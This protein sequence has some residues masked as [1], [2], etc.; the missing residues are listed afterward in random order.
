MKLQQR[1]AA[2]VAQG[3]RRTSEWREGWPVLL[4]GSLAFGMS[5][6]LFVMTAGLFIVPMQE[7]FGWSRTSLSIGPLIV[8]IA[9][10][11]NLVAGFMVRRFG[12]RAV[13]ITG[14]SLL[15]AGILTLSFVPPAPL[16]IYGLAVFIAFA[17]TMTNAPVYTSGVVTWFH[18]N[19]GTAI[20][21]T[22]SGVAIS[23]FLVIPFLAHVIEEFGWRTGYRALAAL[24]LTPLPLLFLWF[25]EKAAPKAAV[26][27][28]MGV[29]VGD[30]DLRSAFADYRLWILVTA[31]G[32][33]TIP[34]GGFVSQ[35][36]PL[37]LTLDFT[38]IAAAALGS[39]F[40]LSIGVGRI[41]AGF[42][43]DHLPPR[44]VTSACLGLSALGAVLLAT[45]AAGPDVGLTALAAVALIGLAQ[46][47]E[48]DF[49]AFYALRLFGKSS[50]PVIMSALIA[51]NAIFLA[52][53]GFVFSRLFDMYDDY[54]AALLLSVASFGMAAIL[55]FTIRL[56]RL[57][58]SSR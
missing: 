19:A 4:S 57:L 20:G 44:F 55:I 11:L 35:L 56:P 39:V 52:L 12:A 15:S 21:L 31:I 32:S 13:A 54:H 42:L 53:G 33:A 40:A 3:P 18:R 41:A 25:R 48:A 9:A 47:A 1:E 46:G 27:G 34:I 8:L 23:S 6:V 43:L 29:P 17:G 45:V 7:E 14:L 37:L 36:V 16:L 58:N 38:L 51:I 50:F 30:K 49:I 24:M 10:P 5:F 26:R 28:S 22:L 2:T